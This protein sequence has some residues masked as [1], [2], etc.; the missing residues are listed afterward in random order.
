MLAT[1]AVVDPADAPAANSEHGTLEDGPSE[2]SLPHSESGASG[3]VAT[4]TTA[5]EG[6]AK[7][8]A[9]NSGA[10]GNGDKVLVE[11]NGKFVLISEAEL[12]AEAVRP[13]FVSLLPF[14]LS[15]T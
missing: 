2:A 7:A 10:A 15:T 4:S 5:P 12:Q 11:R 6:D 3:P 13:L 14:E 1:Q 9:D 8:L